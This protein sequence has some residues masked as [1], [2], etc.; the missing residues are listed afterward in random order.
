MTLRG[1]AE[2]CE[3]IVGPDRAIDTAIAKELGYKVWERADCSKNECWTDLRGWMVLP[4]YTASLDAAEL[5]I[6]SEHKW[7]VY[8]GGYASVARWDGTEA[9]EEIDLDHVKAATP[10]LALCAAALKARAASAGE[11]FGED[12]ADGLHA[13]HEHAIPKGDAQ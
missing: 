5:L 2:R 4:S 3:K 6:P 7:A 13:E 10:A 9:D 1:L 11:A 12:R 8:G